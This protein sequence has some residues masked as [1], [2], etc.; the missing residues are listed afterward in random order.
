MTR[1]RPQRGSTLVVSLIM[2][3]LL[4][5]LALATL[6]TGR[7]SLLV[8]ANAQARAVTQAAAQQVINQVI[9]NRTFAESPDNVLDPSTC[10]SALAAPP[11]SRCVDINGDGRTMV[12]VSLSPA[13]RCV[14]MRPIPT[15]ELDL[16]DS[17]DLGCTQG[18]NSL[19]SGI[20]GA[21]A[22]ASLCAR[23]L[24]EITAV[25]SDPTT[26]A[27]STLVQGVSMRVSTDSATTFC[28]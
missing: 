1:R 15:S 17:E 23:T 28:P 4:T 11:N 16:T 3:T 27:R 20:V 13:P 14:Q 5:I 19:G 26:G 18:L 12:L 6:S 10:P 24:W 2:L 25:A 8:G 7:G 9:S 22:L 21:G